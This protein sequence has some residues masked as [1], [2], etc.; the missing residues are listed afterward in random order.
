MPLVP[1]YA[2]EAGTDAAIRIDP[3]IVQ[4]LGVRLTTVAQVLLTTGDE[5]PALWVASEAVIH[6]GSRDVVIAA[7][8]PGQFIPTEVQ[9]GGE[10]SGRTIILRGLSEGQK[11]V[12][13]GQFLIDSEAGLKGVLA[14]RLSWRR[15]QSGGAAIHTPRRKLL[16]FDKPGIRW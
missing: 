7:G 4:N 1:K 16:H 14:R 15:A 13:S 10:A 6:T 3:T 8:E 12:A 2:D 5:M 9:S 11:V